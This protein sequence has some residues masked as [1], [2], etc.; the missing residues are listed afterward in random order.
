[1]KIIGFKVDDLIRDE[2][3]EVDALAAD[4]TYPNHNVLY[5]IG[6]AIA[7]GKPIIPTVNMAIEGAAKRVQQVGIF[8]T[9]GWL[10]Y[11]NGEQLSEKL[12]GWN[13]VSWANQYGRKRDHSQPLFILDS[14]KKTDFRN[15]IFHAVE[16]SQVEYRK[17]DPEEVS[18]LTAAKA[19]AE[20]SASAGLIVPI[21]G[22]EIVDAYH[23]NLRA[24]FLLGLA[25][26]YGIEALAI[27]YEN[28]PA[29]LDYRDF[30]KNSTFR[31]ET[32]KHVEE[33]CAEILIRNQRPDN[34]DRRTPPG[35][36][37]QV[38]LGSSFAENET[39]SLN[40]YFVETAEYSRALRAEGA[41][42]VGRKGSGK[43]AIF[44]Q[45]ADWALE[46]RKA[47]V[48]DLRPASH[49]LSEMRESL[50]SVVQAGLFD[51]T[52]AAFW[53]YVMYMEIMLK[54]RELVLPKAK[55]NYDL[56]ERIRKVEEEFS[57]TEDIVSGDFTSRL[58][59]AVRMVIRAIEK[60]PDGVS[61]RSQL[62]NVMFEQPIPSLRDSIVS[63]HDQFDG[64]LILLD[65]LDKGW[66]PRRVEEHDIVIVKHLIEVLNRIHRDLG[67]KKMDLRHLIFLRSDIY[68]RLVEQ[69]SDRGKHNLI[70]VDWSDVH[71]LRHL[72]KERIVSGIPPEQHHAVWTAI[73]PT[74][75]SSDAVGI[76]VEHSL[77]RPRFLI[78]LCERVLSFA[79]NRGHQVVQEEDVTDGIRSMSLYLVSDFGYELRD[80]AGTPENT[81]YRF[82]GAPELLTEPELQSL[83]QENE[84]GLPTLEAIDLLL[85]YGF[86]GVVSGTTPVFIYDRGYDF[87]RLQAERPTDTSEILYAVNPA[88]I[89]GLA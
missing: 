84:L 80:V 68:E 51:H 6:F 56:Q 43:S 82:I 42:V 5:E 81:F 44:Q 49:N 20:V 8:D 58:D 64:I 26:G 77:R 59:A 24:A 13:D 17:F 54:I 86:L 25:H 16:N 36:L 85:W 63:F 62:T 10:T 65:D 35:I 61:L 3:R 37:G 88:F 29:P 76:M 72:L 74:I 7:A 83:L 52:I 33:Y 69:T 60:A 78:D 67:R 11:E 55:Y 79:V 9:T 41:V 19:V 45:V 48:V 40:S 53:Q 39:Q 32:E 1:M 34:R 50:L 73:N 89:V 87:R 47:C 22:S 57:L 23:H 12:R 14:L 2:I 75:G 27:Q 18:R 71:Q 28:G 31:R 70:K 38:S 66:P 15:H 30:I 46:E 4:I 21:I